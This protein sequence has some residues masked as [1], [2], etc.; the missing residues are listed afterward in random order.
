MNFWHRDMQLGVSHYY[1]NFLHRQP[2]LPK[3][4]VKLSTFLLCIWEVRVQ[5]LA[6]RLAILTEVSCGFPQSFQV[7]D[8]IV[9]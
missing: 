8:G 9:P 2:K 7:N 6:W 5:I 1:P 4:V 3:V